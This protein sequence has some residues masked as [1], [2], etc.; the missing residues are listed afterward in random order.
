MYIPMTDPTDGWSAPDANG[1]AWKKL[2]SKYG[3]DFEYGCKLAD[4]RYPNTNIQTNHDEMRVQSGS[5]N[6]LI[7]LPWIDVNWPVNENDRWERTS[8]EVASRGIMGYSLYFNGHPNVYDYTLDFRN[9]KGWAFHFKDE[10][11]DI[12]RVATW[13]NGIHYLKYNSRKPTIIMLR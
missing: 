8:P 13:R 11:G 10:T 6:D 5:T 12:Y 1:I 7:R 4:L 9:T 3:K 2:K